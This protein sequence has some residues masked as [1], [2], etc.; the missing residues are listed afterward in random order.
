M[1]AVRD[2][3]GEDEYIRDLA[4]A[5]GMAEGKA[6]GKVEGKAEG[7]AEAVLELLS[8][9]G[10]LPDALKVRIQKETDLQ[11]LGKWLKTAAKA[12]S[13]MDFED[14]MDD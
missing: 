13:I 11:V 10:D 12:E 3:R 8:E 6:E 4:R 7:M 2:R 1:K 5:E 14:K 9:L